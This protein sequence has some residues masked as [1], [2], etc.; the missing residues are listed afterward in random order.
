MLN[1][2]NLNLPEYKFAL[3]F[4]ITIDEVLYKLQIRYSFY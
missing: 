2:F 3:L 1:V 4:L